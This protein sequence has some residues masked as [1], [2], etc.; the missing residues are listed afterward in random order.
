MAL[1]VAGSLIARIV[2]LKACRE[3]A[4]V[5]ITNV[6]HAT[7]L[8]DLRAIYRSSTVTISAYNT[9]GQKIRHRKR[10]DSR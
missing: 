9:T 2:T 6:G 10:P 1:T 4:S 7:L 3:N 8:L 5:K